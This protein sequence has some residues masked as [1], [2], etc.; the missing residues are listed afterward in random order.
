MPQDAG[1]EVGPQ[2][3][4]RHNPHCGVKPG[5]TPGYVA[6]E[7]GDVRSSVAGAA[8]PAYGTA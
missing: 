7:D 4:A 3:P 8:N 6:A 5:A 2:N 1:P